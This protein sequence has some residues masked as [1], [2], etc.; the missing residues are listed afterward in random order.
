ARNDEAPV[1]EAFIEQWLGYRVGLA[2]GGL[3]PSVAWIYASLQEAKYI[4][5]IT[6]KPYPRTTN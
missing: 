1:S 3:Q 4:F 2:L 6:P 5:S